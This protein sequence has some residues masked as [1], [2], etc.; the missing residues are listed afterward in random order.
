MKLVVVRSGIGIPEVEERHV[1]AVCDIASAAGL[2]VERP[3]TREDEVIAVVDAD[4][5]FGGLV[6]AL[7]QHAEKLRWVQAVG[8]GVDRYLEGPFV[9][10]DVVLTSEKGLVGP[11]LAEQAFGLLLALTRGVAL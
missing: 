7:Y 1:E 10:S 4:I 2:A 8:A 9:T 11:H 6:P 5:S 3:Q